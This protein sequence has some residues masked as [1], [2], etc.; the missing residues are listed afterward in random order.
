MLNWQ[1]EILAQVDHNCSQQTAFYTYFKAATHN[2]MTFMLAG[3]HLISPSILPPGFIPESE[4]RFLD[5]KPD[6]RNKEKVLI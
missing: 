2:L 6:L 5:G 1:V 3:D 4:D